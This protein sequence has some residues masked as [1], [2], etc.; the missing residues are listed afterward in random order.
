MITD[1]ISDLI[2][3]IRNSNKVKSRL[4]LITNTKFNFEILSALLKNKYIS[5]IEKVLF[6][7]QIFLL[8]YLNSNEKLLK[9]KG[10]SIKGLKRVSKPSLRIYL[11]IKEIKRL[12]KEKKEIILSTSKGILSLSDSVKK[13]VGGEPLFFI[14]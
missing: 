2:T 5:G 7:K 9:K 1:K 11:K 14:W 3:R 13:Q 4:V 8:V 12:L 6:K 10:L